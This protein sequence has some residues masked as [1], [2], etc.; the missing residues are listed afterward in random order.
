MKVEYEVDVILKFHSA[1]TDDSDYVLDVSLVK[2]RHKAVLLARDLLLD[3]S[4][5]ATCIVRS[6][7]AAHGDSSYLL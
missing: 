5:K 1:T 3:V 6:Q 4:D 2:L 7:F